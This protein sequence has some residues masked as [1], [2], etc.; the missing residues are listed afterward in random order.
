M[1][2]LPPVGATVE[3]HSLVLQSALNGQRGEIVGHQNQ[4]GVACAVV[5]FANHPPMALKPTNLRAVA[6]PFKVGD[7]IEA[8]SLKNSTELNGMA[9]TVVRVE[10]SGTSVV[11][12]TEFP[13]PHGLVIIAEGNA[14]RPAAAQPPAAAAAAAPAPAAAAAPVAPVPFPGS[15]QPP[16]PAAAP[17][18]VAAAAPAQPP[19]AA[20]APPAAAAAAAAP[21]AAAPAAATQPPPVSTPQEAARAFPVSAEVEAVNLLSKPEMNG[22]SGRVM[23]HRKSPDGKPQVIVQFAA[24]GTVAMV[25][26]NLRVKGT[27]EEFPLGSLVRAHSMKHNVSLEG[28]VGKVMGHNEQAQ[29]VVVLFSHNFGMVALKK[30]NV[31]KADAAAATPAAAAPPGGAEGGEAA[32]LRGL[33]VPL[34]YPVHME[35]VLQK[36]TPAMGREYDRR[37]FSLRGP[38]LIYYEEKGRIPLTSQHAVKGD[39]G[40]SSSCFTLSGPGMSRMFELKVFIFWKKAN[41]I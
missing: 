29:Q 5:R 6:D 10:Q 28:A 19:A 3:L 24:Y 11:Y 23:G 15:Q 39:G 2:T 22:A 14:R 33:K 8:H 25:P 31:M 41:V 34:T 16:A 40:A 18:P 17:A 38:C 35:G 12:T 26:A 32:L 37:F 27:A 20:A 7:R 30:Q 1:A 13:D 21:P 4:N 36:K 9:G